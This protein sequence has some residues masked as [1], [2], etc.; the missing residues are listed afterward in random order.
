[1]TPPDRPYFPS[2]NAW[3]TS[4]FACPWPIPYSS[5]NHATNSMCLPHGDALISPTPTR[6][7]RRICSGSTCLR[8][9]GTDATPAATITPTTHAPNTGNPSQSQCTA[10]PPVIR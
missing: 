6:Q 4:A 1:M 2:A 7:S 3:A 5:F 9:I 8:T 10:P